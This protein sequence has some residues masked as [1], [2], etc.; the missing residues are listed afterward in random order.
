[1]EKG[2]LKNL[3]NRYETKQDVLVHIDTYAGGSYI[4]QKKIF[5]PAKTVF[6]AEK[7]AKGDAEILFFDADENSGIFYA[8]T[9]GTPTEEKFTGSVEILRL[10]CKR[11]WPVALIVGFVSLTALAITVI[12]KKRK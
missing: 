4:S 5:I 8:G 7:Y 1:M 6:C 11:V 9:D 3:F 10:L 12:I 2:V